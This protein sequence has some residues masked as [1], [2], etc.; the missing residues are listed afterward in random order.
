MSCYLVKEKKGLNL[1]FL[2]LKKMG[3]SF[4]FQAILNLLLKEST[5]VIHLCRRCLGVQNS[6]AIMLYSCKGKISA[7]VMSGFLQAITLEIR[8]L[9]T[10]M[11]LSGLL[12]LAV[13]TSATST[14]SMPMSSSAAAA[15]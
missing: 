4:H 2:V 14:A 3:I 5:Q 12:V 6:P 10:K 13:M 9:I 1:C 7:L 8:F 15:S 11:Q